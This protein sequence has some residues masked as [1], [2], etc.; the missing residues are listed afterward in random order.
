M[1]LLFT[2]IPAAFCIACMELVYPFSIIELA[3]SITM[4]MSFIVLTA[5]LGLVIGLEMPNLTW[6]SEITPIKQNLGVVIVL[7]GGFAYSFVF[8][9]GFTLLG[10]LKLG[11]AGYMVLAAAVTVIVDVIMWRWLK[12]RGSRILSRL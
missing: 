1:Q 10:G 12:T 8:F 2:V 4:I 6:T 3:L 11:F 7:F 5:E 9:A